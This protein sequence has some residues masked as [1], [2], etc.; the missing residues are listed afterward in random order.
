MKTPRVVVLREGWSLVSTLFTW[1][2]QGLLFFERGVVFGQHFIYMKTP[3]IVVVLREGW[4]LVSTSFAW[5]HQGLLFFERGVV[6]GQHFICMKTQVLFCFVFW[7][8]RGLWS[9][10]HLHENTKD[11]FLG[12]GGWSWSGLCLHINTRERFLKEGARLWSGLRLDENTGGKVFERGVPDQGLGLAVSWS[13]VHR[14]RVVA[15]NT[16]VLLNVK[17]IF[18]QWLHFCC[19]HTYDRDIYIYIYCCIWYVI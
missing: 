15:E 14:K 5:K 17:M 10:L 13:G 7:K 16:V 2:H 19:Q 3:R 4:S 6:F 8:G 12:K 1:K 11:C 9:A 18:Y